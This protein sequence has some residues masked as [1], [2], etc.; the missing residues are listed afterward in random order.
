MNENDR[1]AACLEGRKEEFRVI[2][3]AYQPQV[4]ALALNI[5]GNR[6][7]AEDACQEKIGRAHV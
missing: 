4:M 5:L 6:E 3:S 1:I 7:D 2:V